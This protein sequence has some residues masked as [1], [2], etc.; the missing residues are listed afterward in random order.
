MFARCSFFIEHINDD[1]IWFYRCTKPAILLQ[2][3]IQMQINAHFTRERSNAERNKRTEP[4][5]RTTH[6]CRNISQ[7]SLV[8]LLSFVIVSH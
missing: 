6:I 7:I 1:F 2:T 3:R 4:N 8:R 5:P